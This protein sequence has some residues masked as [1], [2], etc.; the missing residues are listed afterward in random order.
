M[1]HGSGLLFL[2]GGA[3]LA[4]W[5]TLVLDLGAQPKIN[6]EKGFR[7]KLAAKAEPTNAVAAKRATPEQ[8]AFFEKNI[9]PVLVKECYSCHATT[10]KKVRGGLTLD[11]RE[12]V[13]H[14]GE[15]GPAI[16]LGDAKKSLLIK[17]LRHVHE[18]LKMPP[19]KKLPDEVIA[20][21]E[22]WI[23]MGAPDPR[24]GAGKVAKN[25]IDVEKGRRFWSFQPPKKTIPA[26]KDVAWPRGPIDKFVLAGLEAKGLRPVADADPRALIRRI[27]FDLTGLPPSPEEVEA[28]VKKRAAGEPGALEAIV[29]RL[30][31]SPAFGER[32]GRH[33]LDVARYGES[34]GRAANFAYPHAWRYRDYVI[35]SFHADKPYNQFV[36][37]QLAGDLLPAKDDR[38]KAELLVATGFLAIGPKSHD[39]RNR[40]QFQMD[41]ADEQIDVTFQ[42]FQGLTV[43]CARCH[44]HKFD[45]IPQ[46]DYYALAG[47][48]R[49]TETCYGTIRLLQSNHP[50]PLLTLPK[51]AGATVALEPL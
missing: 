40:R 7:K 9:R 26:V 32:W 27:A 45:P 35:K 19:K 11:T 8:F 6:P 47:I 48:F 51:D 39:E 34:S 44:D 1:K 33:W 16:V 17:A 49:S 4:G 41:V 22:K 13:R 15:T 20:N 29:D 5:L 12:G 31:A 14:G 24:D 43:A 2:G 18:P 37:E 23:A 25:E 3:L 38:Q 46:R 10:A 30:L 28:F 42:A 50:S 36:R 21:F